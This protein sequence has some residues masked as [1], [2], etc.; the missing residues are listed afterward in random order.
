MNS[1]QDFLN[2]CESDILNARLSITGVEKGS[3]TYAGTTAKG[4]KVF[5]SAAEVY[6]SDMFFSAIETVE[7]LADSEYF[8][9]TIDGV[10]VVS[11]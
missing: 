10:L 4:K 1:K 11:Y 6:L 7:N 8:T 2:E 3:V 5:V 9:L